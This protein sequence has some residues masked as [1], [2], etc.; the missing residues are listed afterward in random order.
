[1]PILLG[2]LFTAAC[3][4]SRPS[5]SADG[6]THVDAGIFIDGGNCGAMPTPELPLCREG[7]S[8]MCGMQCGDLCGAGGCWRCLSDGGW[9]QTA[10]DCQTECP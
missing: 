7:C 6:G 3:G 9:Q 4:S 2:I 5:G 8:Y 1:M 10:I